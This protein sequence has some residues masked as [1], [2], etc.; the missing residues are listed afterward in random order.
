MQAGPVPPSHLSQDL[1]ERAP[2]LSKD[3]DLPLESMLFGF[4]NPDLNIVAKEMHPKI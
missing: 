4:K 2:P 3:L 1:D